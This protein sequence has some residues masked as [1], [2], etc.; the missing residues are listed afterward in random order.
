M[1]HK[2]IEKDFTFNINFNSN[3]FNYWRV[4][5]KF[6]SVYDAEHVIAKWSWK[7]PFAIS[8]KAIVKVIK[9]IDVTMIREKQGEKLGK[10]LKKGN[11]EWRGKYEA[12]SSGD[13]PT[14]DD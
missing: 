2:L 14:T 13:S 4:K 3:I 5:R 6:Y 7:R 9:D 10:Q 1:Q 11:K 8:G 12:L